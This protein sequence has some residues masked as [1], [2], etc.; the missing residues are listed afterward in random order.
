MVWTDTYVGAVVGENGQFALNRFSGGAGVALKYEPVLVATISSTGLIRPDNETTC[1]DRDGI[2]SVKAAV[3]DYAMPGKN[4]VA[5]TPEESGA[6]YAASATGWVAASGT[7]D[8]TSG[9]LTIKNTATGLGSGDGSGATSVE[10]SAFLPV[11]AGDNFVVSYSGLSS[12]LLR[13]IH[14]GGNS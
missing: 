6:T 8:G 10:L 11:A 13:F 2:L 9:R 4:Y 3:A 7:T 5:L 12:I 14:G 1:V